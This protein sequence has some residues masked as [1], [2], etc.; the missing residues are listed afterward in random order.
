MTPDIQVEQDKSFKLQ[1]QQQLHI[2]KMLSYIIPLLTN[3]PDTFFAVEMKLN[4]VS[5]YCK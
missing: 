3:Y 2:M 4:Q 5:P 1:S